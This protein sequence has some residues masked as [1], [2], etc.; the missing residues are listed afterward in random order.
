MC[1]KA[2]PLRRCVLGEP[3]RPHRHEGSCDQVTIVLFAVATLSNGLERFRMP[4]MLPLFVLVGR[5]IQAKSAS[6]HYRGTVLHR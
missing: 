2:A 4:I 5:A 3:R 1:A 6:P